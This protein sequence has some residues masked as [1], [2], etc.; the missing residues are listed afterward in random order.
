[1]VFSGLPYKDWKELYIS[2]ELSKEM[3]KFEGAFLPQ[4]F[5]RLFDFA[6]L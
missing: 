1:M 6:I 4:Q 2:T 5:F 3:K